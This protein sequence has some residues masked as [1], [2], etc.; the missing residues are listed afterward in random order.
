M[1]WGQM[2][3]LE[4][5]R[6]TA[7]HFSQLPRGAQVVAACRGGARD[8]VTGCSYNSGDDASGVYY[9]SAYPDGDGQCR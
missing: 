4:T 2:V 1:Q 7:P 6:A 9:P 5:R 3:E 8:R